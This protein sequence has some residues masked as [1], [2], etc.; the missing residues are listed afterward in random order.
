MAK[1]LSSTT[2]SHPGFPGVGSGPSVEFPGFNIEVCTHYGAD[3]LADE[4]NKLDNVRHAL[5]CVLRDIKDMVAEGATTEL[6]HLLPRMRSV[7]LYG[8]DAPLGE[9]TDMPFPKTREMADLQIMAEGRVPG[10]DLERPAE[11]EFVG[12]FGIQQLAECQQPVAIRADR[13]KQAA[14][15]LTRPVEGEFVGKRVVISSLMGNVPVGSVVDESECHELITC[16]HTGK[17]VP[18]I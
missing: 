10:V 18:K 11:G 5:T 2:S 6:V 9:Q 14:I 13:E 16:I 3:K 12:N 17:L 15:L 8:V 4:L 1:Y 7:L